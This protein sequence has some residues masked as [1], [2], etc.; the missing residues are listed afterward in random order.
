MS[1]EKHQGSIEL[2]NIGGIRALTK[3]NDWENP[4][5]VGRNKRPGHVPLGAYPDAKTAL[6][7]DRTASPYVQSL[8]GNWK[9][10]LAPSPGRV[11]DGFF[12][13]DFDVSGW[14]EITVPGNW[15]L[16]GF[17]DKPI[18]TNVHYPFPRHPPLVPEQNPTGCYRTTFT[19]NSN[20]QGRDVLLLFESVDSAFY[21][22]VNGQEVGYSQGSRLPA[23][24]DITPYL[25]T[26][27]NTLAAQV[28]RYCD[29][30]YLED[31]DMWLMSGIQRDVVLYSKPKICLLDFTVRTE[32]DDQYDDATLKIEAFITR[33]P[34]MAAYSVEAML[35]DAD[36]AP[37]FAEHVAA[38]VSDRTPYRAETK[39][40]CAM[41]EQRVTAPHKWTA[42]T[43]YL[44][45]LVLTLKDPDGQPV[46]FESCRVGFRQ[47]KVK[48]GVVLLNG[49]RLIVRG[50][51][52]HEH[53]P[54]RG[55]AVTDADM[56]RDIKLM[57][58]LNFNAVR[59]S[60]YPNHPRW[61]DLCDEYG[62]F[63]IDEAN[64]E[65]HGVHG[66]L[67]HD[68]TWAHAYMERATRLV[69]R[70][71]NHPCVLFWS[72]GNESGTGPH[73]A[74]MAAWIRAYDP[75]RLVQYESGHPGPE[76]SDVYCPMYPRLDRVRQVLADPAE[77]R[78]LIMCEYAYAK[79]NSTG[80]FF[81][82]WDLVDEVPRFQGGCI[83]DWHDKALLHTNA[84][85][86]EY[87]AYGGDFGGDFDYNQDNEDPQMCCNGIVGPDLSPHPGAY[88]VKKV[89]AP[90]AVSAASER[91]VLEGRFTVWNKYHTLSLNHL[92][93]RWEL[94][95]DG[96]V[97][98]SGNLAP[99]HLGPDQ[100][101]SLHI[102]FRPPGPP[103]PGAQ[104]YFRISFTLADDTP[105]ALKGH[106]VAWD[107]FRVPL[108][109]PPK[110]VMTLDSMPNLTQTSED[111]CVT[112][113]GADFRVVFDQAQGTIVE[114]IARGQDLI[115]KGPM[116]NFDRAPTDI[117]LMMGNPPA[118][119]HK[120]R[121]AGLDRLVRTVLSFEA[122][123]LAPQVVQVC[124][125][126][127][128]CAAD[129]RDGIDSEMVYRV[130]GNGEVLLK[131][132]V[133]INKRLPFVPRVGL[134][135][136]LPGELEQ[137]TWYGRG[138]H[139]NYVD[140]KKGAAVGLYRSTVTD[141]FTPYVYP[142]ECGGKED[143]R[144]LTLTDQAGTGLMVVGLDKL[145]FDALYY[146][147]RDLAA[148]GHPYELTRRDEVILHLDGWH[149]GVGG[150]DGW[151]SQVHEEFLIY[152]GE[153]H[154]ALRLRP[155]TAQDDV[156]ELG[157]TLIK[158]V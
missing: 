24:F 145:H 31:Q 126:A 96:V 108:A 115:N 55:R 134:E 95:A 129:K 106:E 9:F 36:G 133:S 83:W 58:Q 21:L 27:K 148:A 110:P 48:D 61:Y 112:V 124:I 46:D 7:C 51:N 44:Y 150:D 114:Y 90:V 151:W 78:P 142:S 130:Y 80:N 144:W 87:W 107:Q 14:D 3:Q 17:A 41:I 69:L 82:Y 97:I 2:S 15:Q 120:W 128:L 113:E 10:H 67:S 81:K 62:L 60:H 42:E 47:V 138:P 79:G 29:G 5:V 77:K 54:Q 122:A 98:Q 153:Y 92:D 125:S 28:M 101:G 32:F 88:E 66:E 45:R 143:V 121:A 18:Y 155:I 76:I 71:K 89:Q 6:T 147:I 109:V 59:T 1:A 127:R 111:N 26:G 103:M 70:D 131:H 40:A 30:S 137:L 34:G 19:L 63:V 16:Q 68:P 73:H 49:K 22:W 117:D 74:A 91:D 38:A 8:N 119:V 75:T 156:S 37:V 135:L 104:Y 139:E 132:K 136:I 25:R 123:Q 11:P 99:L 20:W 72:L 140:R 85:G 4:L 43:P 57:K 33:V 50:V 105:W 35:Y 116:E 94:A 52:R 64:I 65:S 154:Y 141:Q 157:R 149:M 84:R 152:P 53:H 158:D 86:E 39:T 102:P 93:I 13:E 100:K 146:T 23:E 118:N 56:I 12:R